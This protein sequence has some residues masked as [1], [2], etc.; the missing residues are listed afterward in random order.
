MKLLSSYIKEMKIAARG[1]Y[2]YI[3][4]GIAV[5]MLL[6]LL[7]AVSE[8]PVSNEKSYLKNDLPEAATKAMIQTSIDDGNAKWVDDTEFELKPE[9][10]KVT[11]KETGE[12]TKYNFDE[13]KT[14][15]VKTLENYDPKTKEL[16]S[17]DYFFEDEEDLIRVLYKKKQ[18]GAVMS[19]SEEG[20]LTHK[21][22]L[23]GFETERMVDLLSVFNFGA[24]GELEAASEKISVRTIGST[25]RLNN[26]QNLVPAFL[27]FAGTLMGLF[28]VMAYIFLDKDEGVIKAFAVTPSSVWKYL[29]SK[30]LI[31]LTTVTVSSSIITIPVMGGQPN[32]LLFYLYLLITTFAF[33]AVGLLVASFFDSISKSFGFMYGLMIVLMLPAF[34]YYIPSFDPLWL[35]FF[36]T[37]PILQGYKEI[38]LNSNEIGYVL[39]YAGIFLGAGILIFLLANQRFKKTLTV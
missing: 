1:F 34:S 21:Y 28:I 31:I 19:L 29:L 3:E 39:M 4:I 12:V 5:I 27:T 38:L 13:G 20:E 36:P 10:F 32:Y 35:R 23:Q 33:A 14:I 24:I 37:Y 7:L 26:R 6:V 11:N 9:S 17:T 22:Y 2:F 25:E 8:N 30:A 16:A 18:I 15:T